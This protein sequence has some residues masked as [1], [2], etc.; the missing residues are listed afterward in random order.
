MRNIVLI[1]IGEGDPEHLTVRA[2][3]AMRSVD[4]F[5]IL[6]KG[7]RKKEL[8][9]FRAEVLGRYVPEGGYRI[10]EANDPPRDRSSAEYV[11]AVEDWRKRRA[12]VCERMIAEELGEDETGA[13]L[14]WGDPTLYDSTL[15][16]LEDI[17]ARGTL[18]FEYT[19]IPGVSSVSSLVARHRTGLNRIGRPVQIT[20]GRRLAEGFPDGVDDVVVML[21]AHCTFAEIE[22]AG[23]EIY[24]GAYLG[25]PEEVTVSGT[26]PEVAE[27]I[28]RVRA[29]ARERN[30]WIMDTYLL[31]R[32][33][34]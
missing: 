29:E 3:E 7:E 27:E 4:V 14:V 8:V 15:G 31:R 1:G 16:I 33:P 2:V 21:D 19:V 28:K 26:L 22:N 23:M 20:T 6:D 18:S 12:D 10:A 17:L 32:N 9:D 5:F 13:F 34:G 24:W 11:S 30:G 25:T